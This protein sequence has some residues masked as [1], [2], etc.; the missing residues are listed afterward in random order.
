MRELD[1][2]RDAGAEADAVVGAVDVVVHRLRTGDDVYCFVVQSLAVAERVVASDWDQYVDS[3]MLEIPEHVFRDVVD[4]LV[5]AG[6]MRRHPRA[7]QVA[8]SSARRVEE[9]AAG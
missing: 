7:R 6:E 8:R 3:D 2:A 1:R 4:R 9:S 5:V